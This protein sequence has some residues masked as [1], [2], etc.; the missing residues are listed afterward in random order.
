MSS[1][2]AITIFIVYGLCLLLSIIFSITN[3]QFNALT[4]IGYIISAAFIALLVFD[5]NC[6]SND[7]CNTWSWIRTILYSIFP[8]IILII[9]IYS[10]FASKKTTQ[11]Q[12]QT[13][14]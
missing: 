13:P 9:I 5:T 3:H 1:K 11:E 14:K 10:I 7:T 12:N 2:Q 4:S 6:L 8:C